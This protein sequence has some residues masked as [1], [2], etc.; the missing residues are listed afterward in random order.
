MAYK[1]RWYKHLEDSRIR[2]MSTF[3]KNL[4]ER[5]EKF[6][7]GQAKQSTKE[8]VKRIVEESAD[9][10]IYME[11]QSLQDA[12][13]ELDNLDEKKD[14]VTALLNKVEGLMD[15][16]AKTAILLYER[17][18]TAEQGDDNFARCRKI[19]AAGLMAAA[20]LGLN[21]YEVSGQGEQS[22]KQ[23]K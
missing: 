22:N 9:S 18:K 5:L 1:S 17:V 10:L 16:R 15:D 2:F 4:D 7:N 3:R 20:Y 14:V 12:F 21:R 19:T 6:L 23:L 11:I 8:C 13:A